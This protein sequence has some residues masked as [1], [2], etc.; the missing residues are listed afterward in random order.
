MTAAILAFC[1]GGC[2]TF[3]D[4]GSRVNDEQQS[5]EKL[6][7]KRDDYQERLVIVLNNL[8]RYPG[9]PR[10]EKER[11]LV[12]GKLQEVNTQIDQQRELYRQSLAEW[13]QKINDDKIQQQMIDKE[14]KA[15]STKPDGQ[16]DNS[17]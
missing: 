9:D 1:G 16:W 12:Q 5:L 2:A 11:D 7:H 3:T 8:E 17:N 13:E 6:E 15:D 4:H 14:E 10:M